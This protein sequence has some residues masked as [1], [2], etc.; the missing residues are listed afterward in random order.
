[1]RR[2]FSIIPGLLAALALL[3]PTAP[4]A[5]GPAQAAGRKDDRVTIKINVPDA[6][7]TAVFW[8]SQVAIFNE[9][10]KTHPDINVIAAQGIQLENLSDATLM[11]IAGGTAPDIFDVYYQSMGTYIEQGFIAPL[12]EYLDKWEGRDK[13]PPQCWPVVTGQ[14]GKR[15]GAVYLWPTVYL[16]YRR[17]FF[18][19]AGLDPNRPPQTWEELWEAAKKLS[20]PNLKVATALDAASRFGRQGMFL[21][22]SGSWIFSNFVWQ[23]GGEIVRRRKSD[24]KWECVLDEPGNVTALEYYKKLR[25]T[26]WTRCATETCRAKNICYDISDKDAN[27]D[28]AVVTCPVCGEKVTIMDIKS[29][30][31]LYRGVLRTAVGGTTS[32]TYDRMFASSEVAMAIMP[33]QQLQWVLEKN[34]VRAEVIGIAP[35]PAGP[36]GRASIVDGNAYAINSTCMKDKRKM[37][38]AWEYI[39]FATSDRANEIETKVYVETGYGRFVRNPHWLETFG[40][41]EY[42]DEIDTVQM[43]AY[44]TLLKYGHPEPFCPNYAAMGDDMNEPI[45]KVLRDPNTDPAKELKAVAKRLN[46]HLFK[47][48]PVD[49]MRYK[50]RALT[51]AGSILVV[52][53]LV[54]CYLLV[55]SLAAAVAN[56][57]SGL[58]ATLKA[59]AWKHLYA[60][61]FLAPAVATVL[62]WSYVPLV[63]GSVMAFYDYKILGGSL[64][65]GVD[66][67]VDAVSQPVFWHSLYT[68]FFYTALT[69]TFGFFTPI[70]LSLLL[71]E[72]PRLKITFRMLFYL[73][74]LTSGLVLM[75]LWKDLFFNASPGGLMN[76]ILDFFGLPIQTWLQ[77]PKL[78]MYCIVLPGVWAGAGPGSIIYLAALK[79][80]PDEMYEAAE[81]DGASVF[82]KI[83]LVTLPYLKPLII[84]N[85]FGAFVG[86]FQ[87]TQNIFV[88]TM[89]GPEKATHT[90]SLE[91]FLNAFQYLKFGYATAMGWIM[92]S[93]LIGFTLYQ[94]RVFQRV[95]FTAGGTAD[96]N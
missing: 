80:V 60:W 96:R 5:E 72:V 70:A 90:L 51:A 74:A 89:G 93:M 49:E 37:D 36:G 59:S 33:L 61:L 73:P 85:F 31:R 1:M 26:Y 38:A 47:L 78:A 82:Q 41:K 75:F 63:R 27:N 17:D 68:T 87:A 39:R 30:E 18:E 69:M 65:I 92:G 29:R 14:D 16:V 66:N 35:L 13:V 40:Y 46:T 52:I 55:K 32:T 88:M 3:A 22:T 77:D 54:V 53:V 62:L 79:T 6:T 12:D 24:N 10:V 94:L 28:S 21:Q 76:R 4:G 83:F 67:F 57:R 44:D 25:W 56:I 81:M 2:S 45:S 11:G 43:S 34:V 42:Y 23:A 84:I 8:R 20:Q 95:Q 71:A 19:Q 50:R 86:S 64:W 48:Y 15:Y 58:S 91:I 7:S 9:F